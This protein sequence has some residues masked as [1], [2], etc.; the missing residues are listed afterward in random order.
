MKAPFRLGL[1]SFLII[2]A[3]PAYAADETAETSTAETT[4]AQEADEQVNLDAVKVRARRAPSKLGETKTKREEL[5]ENLVQDVRDLVRYDPAVS[6][7]EG[8]RGSTNGFAIRGV[9]KDRVAINVDGLAQAESRSSEAFQELFGAYGNFN[10]NR[11]AAELENISAVSIRKGA[12]SI[13]SGSGAL[14]G[15]VDYTTKSPRDVVNADKPLYVGVKGG[16]TGRNG[17]YMGSTDLAAY[18]KGF[19]A[20]FVYTRRHGHETK[21]NNNGKE[22]TAR[23]EKDDVY[24]PLTNNSSNYGS[25]G[26]F[27]SQP[28]P[29]SYQSKSTLFKLGYHFNDYNYLYGTYEDNRVDRHTNELS[30]LWAADWQGNIGTDYRKRND[31]TYLKRTGIAY[32]NQLLSGPWD[33]LTLS[34]DK[35]KIQMSTFSWD[36][37]TNIAARGVNSELY[38]TFRRINQDTKQFLAKASKSLDLGNVGW[39]MSY[40]GGINKNT[41]TNDHYTVFVNVFDPTFEKSNRSTQEFLLEAESK[42]KH[43]FWNNS[44]NFNNFRIGAGI[45]HDW[46]NNKTL[47][48]EDFINAM[49]QKGL[50]DAKAKFGATSYALSFD[51]RFAPGWTLLSKYST[52]FRAPTTDEMWFTFPHPD[53]TVL[54]NPKL[55]AEKAHNY[56]L[57]IS[58]RGNWGNFLLSGF[59]TRY[60]DFIDFAYLGQR[61]TEFWNQNTQQWQPRGYSAPTWQNVNRDEATINGVELSGDWNLDSVGLPRGFIM[62]WTASYLKGKAKQ[63]DGRKTPI[64]ALAPFGAVVGFGY[65]QPEDR[66]SL[67]TNL[68]Y[69]ARKKTK[70]TIHNNDDQSNPW[71]YTKHSKNYFLVDLL[72]HYMIGK[73]VTIRGGIFNLFDKKYY[74]WDSLR[75]IREFGT[76]NR[77]DNCNDNSGVPQHASCSHMGIQRFAAPGRSYGLTIEAKF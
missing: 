34:Y 32:E 48:N 27:R 30:N 41:N 49:R 12:D 53:M 37:P 5:D 58:N 20:R 6:I 10:A 64:N 31:I 77:V 15:A 65:V 21:S 25:Y 75:S 71:P 35:Q 55:K 72:G 7:V 59:H 44:F 66:W 19:D 54:A 74:T 47:P 1:I 43:V 13:T 46:V 73:N 67:R 51:W 62:N 14:G 50:D 52:G 45:R 42:K 29:Q 76:V 36:V 60:K 17:E 9:D 18:F 11:N 39:S 40:G 28:D 68:S 69:T 57:G 26:K 8:G 23:F 3:F 38:Q 24:N 22:Y 16:Y 56:E 4:A 70:D 61:S 33:K 2:S 63:E